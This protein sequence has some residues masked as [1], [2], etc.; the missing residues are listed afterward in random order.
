[1]V[2]LGIV[3]ERDNRAYIDFVFADEDGQFRIGLRSELANEGYTNIRDCST[4]AHLESAI[5]SGTPDLLV[6]E[7]R[8]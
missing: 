6:L 2:G 7:A 8:M 5:E 3:T 4:I 1:M